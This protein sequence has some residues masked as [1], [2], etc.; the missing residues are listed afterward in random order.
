MGKVVVILGLLV[1][2]KKLFYWDCI[3]KN[4]IYSLIENLNIL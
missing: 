3:L 4:I 2:C 1:I